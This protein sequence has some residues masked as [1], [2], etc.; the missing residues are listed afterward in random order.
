[1]LIHVTEMPR[2]PEPHAQIVSFE[3]FFL[4]TIFAHLIALVG[5]N[6][7]WTF[8]M[9]Q[10]RWFPSAAC[11]EPTVSVPCLSITHISFL[12]IGLFGIT[13]PFPWYLSV[14]ERKLLKGK[15]RVCLSFLPLGIISLPWESLPVFSLAV[16]NNTIHIVLQ[17]GKPGN[18]IISWIL[19]SPDTFTIGHCFHS[20][21]AASFFLELSILDTFWPGGLIFWCHIFLPVRGVLVTRILERFVIPSSSGPRFV[22]ILHYNL[23]I[24]GGP[25]WHDS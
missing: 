25:A 9:E 18:H 13:C 24:L 22:R 11:L 12:I 8:F 20:S 5:I 16:G 4:S 6:I 17:S 3:L 15:E 7:L 2:R 14:G 19:S 23:Y 1:M 10:Q 21:P